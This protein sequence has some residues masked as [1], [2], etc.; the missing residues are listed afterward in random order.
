MFNVYRRLSLTPITNNVFQIS[1]YCRKELRYRRLL[2]V[3]KARLQTDPRDDVAIVYP[4]RLLPGQVRVVTSASLPTPR[5]H[6][7]F[8]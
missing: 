2:T 5:H 1:H 3:P 6:N 8:L 4:W 7:I